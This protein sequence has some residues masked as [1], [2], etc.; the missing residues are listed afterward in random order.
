IGTNS[1]RGFA[2][3]IAHHLAKTFTKMKVGVGI[4]QGHDELPLR[5]TCLPATAYVGIGDIGHITEHVS[6]KWPTTPLS[7]VAC[8]I[9]AAHFTRWAGLNAMQLQQHRV[10]GA[11]LV[12]HGYSS[13][14]AAGAVDAS[15]AAPVILNAYRDIVRKCADL[16]VLANSFPGFEPQKLKSARNLREWDEALLPVYGF[17]EH[18]HVMDAV[19][20]TPAMLE[21]LSIPVIFLAAENDPLTPATR[22]LDGQ[23]HKLVKNSAVIHTS[24]GSHMAWWEGPPWA[25]HQTWA[26]S[27]MS[28]AVSALTGL[29]I[30]A[31]PSSPSARSECFSYQALRKWFG[32]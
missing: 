9:G 22:L 16:E 23:V 28:E 6:S 5:S 29:P 24:H 15:G 31:T 3:M 14:H 17:T 30:P 25:M 18:E 7:I 4:L 10:Q 27:L 32:K 12:C 1:R 8:S 2:G 11:V 19:D 13:R 21:Q 26:C 20:T